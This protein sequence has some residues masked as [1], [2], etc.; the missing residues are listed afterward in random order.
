[1]FTFEIIKNYEFS[2][3]NEL[4]FIAIRANFKVSLYRH[5]NG[6]KDVKVE[7]LQNHCGCIKRDEGPYELVKRS[8]RGSLNLYTLI[9]TFTLG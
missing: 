9:N 1:M 5:E 3:F 2:I 6:K 8:E 4:S 7:P